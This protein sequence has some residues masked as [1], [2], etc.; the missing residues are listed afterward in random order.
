MIVQPGLQN[1]NIVDEGTILE[2]TTKVM[3]QGSLLGLILIDIFSSNLD[4]NRLYV[5]KIQ[6]T[7]KN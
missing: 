1:S 3:P 7:Y 4:E 2:G 5:I 6:S